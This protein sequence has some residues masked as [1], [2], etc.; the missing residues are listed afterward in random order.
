[1]LTQIAV[2]IRVILLFR[3]ESG[4]KYDRA[5]PKNVIELEV[6]SR[7]NGEKPD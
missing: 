5:S 6:L 1:M 3:R 4:K 7:K 2:E